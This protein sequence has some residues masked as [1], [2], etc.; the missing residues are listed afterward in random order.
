MRNSASECRFAKF[1]IFMDSWLSIRGLLGIGRILIRLV[2]FC[3][4]FGSRLGLTRISLV[5]IG[6]CQRSRRNDNRHLLGT[7]GISELG[8]G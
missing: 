2:N 1:K 6:R 7:A 4:P 5:P 3:V 8:L